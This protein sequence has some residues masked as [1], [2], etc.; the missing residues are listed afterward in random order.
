MLPRGSPR[1]LGRI[2]PFFQDE[3]A[4]VPGGSLEVAAG[5]CI[6]NCCRRHAFN[7]ISNNLG[8]NMSELVTRINGICGPGGCRE[9]ELVEQKVCH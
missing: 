2:P 7:N 4:M 5:K 3:S 9:V 1:V 8:P 6:K